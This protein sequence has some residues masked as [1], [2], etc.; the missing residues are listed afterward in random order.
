MG[1]VEEH[2]LLWCSVSLHAGEERRVS[3]RDKGNKDG[4]KHPPQEQPQGQGPKGRGH[5]DADA[6]GLLSE[7]SQRLH[8]WGGW[9]HLATERGRE[10]DDSA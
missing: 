7:G 8:W 9:E 2:G 1:F 6:G 5:S 10:E 3:P 4:M